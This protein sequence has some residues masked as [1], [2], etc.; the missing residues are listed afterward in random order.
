MSWISINKKFLLKIFVFFICVVILINKYTLSLFDPTPP[1]SKAATY[2]MYFI[3]VGSLASG[4]IFFYC[5]TLF[6][7]IT[8]M[9]VLLIGIDL[10]TSLFIERVGHKEFRLQQPQPYT[11]AKYF[12]KDFIDETFRQ[13]GGWLLDKKYGG[14]KPRNFEGKWINVRNNRRVTINEP[15]NYLRKIYL[16]GGSTVYNGEVPDNL[17]IASHLASLGANNFSYEVVN[18]GATSI[19]SAQEFGRLKSEIKLNSD[20][21]IIF[22]NGVN[23]VLQRIIYE[24]HE[25]YMIG[26]PKQE[27]FWIKQL[28]SKSKY[29]SILYIFYSKIIENTK[30]TPSTLIKTSIDHYVNTLVLVNE[31]VK[32]QGASF[33]HFLQPTLFTKKNLNKYEK[34]LIEKGFPFV[35]AQF[36]QDF[37]RAYPL[38]LNKLDSIQFSYSLVGAFDDLEESPYLDFC[39]VTHIGNKIIAKNIWNKTKDDLKF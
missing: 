26:E 12:S 21:V 31:Y 18:M 36:I 14:V 5:R 6:I 9:L 34:I 3:Y 29:S 25:G 4:V 35:P 16:F 28:R 10:I 33:Y 17:T 23:D 22:Y 11:N 37:K 27:S 2:I 7:Q 32:A 13:P 8:V 38:I 30:E 39:H 1:L 20:D 24:N 19:H 15:G